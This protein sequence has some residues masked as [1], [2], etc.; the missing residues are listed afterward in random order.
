MRVKGFA[1]AAPSG[2]ILASGFPL[3]GLDKG[4]AFTLIMVKVFFTILGVQKE[5]CSCHRVRVS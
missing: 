4:P 3:D 1:I 2:W 5:I